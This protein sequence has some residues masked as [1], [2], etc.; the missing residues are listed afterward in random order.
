MFDYHLHTSH[1]FDAHT[2]PAEMLE[3]AARA[4][5]REICFTDHVDLDGSDFP[6]ADLH[7]LAEDVHSLQGGSVAVRF[8]AEFSLAD[9]A[10][11]SRSREYLKGHKPDF[12]IGSAH[13]MDGVDPYEEKQIFEQPKETVYRH[14]LECLNRAI[15]TDFP[16]SV[17][18]HY[19]YIAKCATYADRSFSL[20]SAPELFD[21]IFTF[22]ARNGKGIEINTAA[23]KDDP[24][25]GLDIL[26]R[27]RACGGVFVT[28]GSDAHVPERVGNRISEALDM[29]RAAGIPYVATFRQMEPVL[30]PL[31]SLS[32]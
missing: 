9:E 14:Y 16:F 6:L 17:L 2:P 26:K 5:L 20:S 25:W 12:I 7:A 8:G 10:C 4:G 18:G 1:S 23:W 15:R 21:E 29:A 11:A 13:L 24:A 19:D 27:Y 30:H 28:V 3:A 32:V 31:S 22:L